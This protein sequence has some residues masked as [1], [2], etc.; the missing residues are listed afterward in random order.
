MDI[1]QLKVEESKFKKLD[2]NE[3]KL[4]LGKLQQL[5]KIVDLLNC[6]R[7]SLTRELYV[8]GCENEDD[9]LKQKKEKDANENVN[10]VSVDDIKVKCI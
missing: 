4:T 6:M 9:V 1:P 8:N 3:K 5:E 10:D 7:E 2:D